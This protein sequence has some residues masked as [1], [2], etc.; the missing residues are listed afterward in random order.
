MWTFCVITNRIIRY[1]FFVLF[2][3]LFTYF[4]V[5]CPLWAIFSKTQKRALECFNEKILNSFN[6]SNHHKSSRAKH[7]G[8][9]VVVYFQRLNHTK[10]MPRTPM[11]RGGGRGTRRVEWCALFF[12]AD[13]VA[14]FVSNRRRANFGR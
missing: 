2:L 9:S 7:T 10:K 13:F 6:K 5:F 3:F 12:R 4:S 14:A 11:G 8:A 1:L